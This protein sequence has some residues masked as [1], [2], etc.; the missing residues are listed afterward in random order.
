MPRDAI[1]SDSWCECFQ[2]D[3]HGHTCLTHRDT[4]V[5]RV[6]V[7]EVRNGGIILN[8]LE[9]E[10]S[11]LR[12]AETWWTFTWNRKH[13]DLS[14][15]LNLII[16]KIDLRLLRLTNIDFEKLWLIIRNVV[17]SIDNLCYLMCAI[18]DWNLIFWIIQSKKFKLSSVVM[19]WD[20]A[21]YDCAWI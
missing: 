21:Q 3:T 15:Q 17:H 10:I 1:L 5:P 2:S 11:F 12:I 4:P 6:N 16:Q 19:K 14:I 7:T 18:I 20:V 9:A 8:E 13:M